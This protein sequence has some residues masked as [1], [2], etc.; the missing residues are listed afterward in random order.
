MPLD[1][2]NAHTWSSDT[3][4]RGFHDYIVAMSPSAPTGPPTCYLWSMSAREGQ[5]GNLTQRGHLL[6]AGQVASVYGTK[7]PGY[8]RQ[9]AANEPPGL[10]SYPARRSHRTFSG[11]DGAEPM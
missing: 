1:P 8:L 9:Q 6:R 5:L 11:A 7:A 10:P 4:R 3:A 2:L